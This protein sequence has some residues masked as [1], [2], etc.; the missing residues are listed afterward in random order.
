MTPA[1]PFQG[2]PTASKGAIFPDGFNSVNGTTGFIAA[3]GHQVRGDGTLVKPD[4]QDEKTT[5]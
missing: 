2:K 4:Q 1:Q 3:G 5:Q